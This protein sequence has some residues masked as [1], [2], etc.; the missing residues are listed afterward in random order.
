VAALSAR[1][2]WTPAR[3]PAG[4]VTWCELDVERLESSPEI[5]GSGAQL[6]LPRRI[7]VAVQVRPAVVMR[8][9]KVELVVKFKAANTQ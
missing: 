7:P 8:D 2:N 5:N 4:K 6:C 3:E 1:W 9:P